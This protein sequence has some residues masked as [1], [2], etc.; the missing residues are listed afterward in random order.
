MDFEVPDHQRAIVETAQR[1]ATESLAPRA[2]H[3]DQASVHPKESWHDVWRNGLL[4]GAIPQQYGG[5][6][7]DMLSYCKITSLLGRIN[8]LVILQ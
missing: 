8:T 6:E 3:Y 4:A 7:L 2:D 1:L 5:L